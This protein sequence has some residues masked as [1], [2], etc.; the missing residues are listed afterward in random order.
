M[1]AKVLRCLSGLATNFFS[2]IEFP[3]QFSMFSFSLSDMLVQI[4]GTAARA[5][6]G[7][8]GESRIHDAIKFREWLTQRAHLYHS[9]V[10]IS[11]V[12]PILGVLWVCAS[13]DAFKPPF[14]ALVFASA[15]K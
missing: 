14:L 12:S 8:F 11:R 4:S 5:Q 10:I 6:P 9:L 1:S 7:T 15:G 2:L 13:L 3:S